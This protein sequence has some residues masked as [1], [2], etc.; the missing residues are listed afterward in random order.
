[1]AP[2]KMSLVDVC[3]LKEGLDGDPM[4]IE[5]GYHQKSSQLGT[6]EQ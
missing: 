6:H 3:P 2:D 1:M 4:L 5:G